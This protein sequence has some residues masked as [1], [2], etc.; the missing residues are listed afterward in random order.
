M[1]K[2][3]KICLV[4]ALTLI[5]IVGVIAMASANDSNSA[6]SKSTKNPNN[7]MVKKTEERLNTAYYDIKTA[8]SLGETLKEYSLV[9][10]QGGTDKLESEIMQQFESLDQSPIGSTI[11]Q[12]YLKHDSSAMIVLYKEGDGSNVMR[13]ARKIDNKWVEGERRSRGAAILNID[14]IKV[15]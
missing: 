1:F 2:N 7:I 6:K 14:E 9:D 5:S 10:F 12:Y 15:E 4:L 13:Y 11:P 3:R 8:F